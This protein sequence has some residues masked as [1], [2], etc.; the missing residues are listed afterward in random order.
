MLSESKDNERS[1]FDMTME[2]NMTANLTESS[3]E[4]GG[5]RRFTIGRND[6]FMKEFSRETM[7]GYNQD[8]QEMKKPQNVR[9][10]S[11]LTKKSNFSKEKT[12]YRFF[13]NVLVHM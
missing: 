10:I 3:K 13:C 7:V 8:L 2:R 11:R 1:A 6:W 5:E 12:H 4:R 9:V